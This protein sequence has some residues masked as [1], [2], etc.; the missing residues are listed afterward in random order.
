MENKDK[1]GEELLEKLKHL[2]EETFP[3]QQVYFKDI[4]RVNIPIIVPTRTITHPVFKSSRKTYYTIRFCVVEKPPKNE[5]PLDHE[6]IEEEFVEQNKKRDGGG[7]N[8]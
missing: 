4:E 8:E 5:K 1:Q 3:N 2:L 7:C 6:F